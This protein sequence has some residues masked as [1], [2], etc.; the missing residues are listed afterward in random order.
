LAT[1]LVS[2]SS[3]HRT[4]ELRAKAAPAT[5]IAARPGATPLPATS[6]PSVAPNPELEPAAS[7]AQDDSEDPSTDAPLPKPGL[8]GEADPL[9]QQA[10]REA[11]VK[12]VAEGADGL[13][14]LSE[15]YPRD[16]AVLKALVQSFASRSETLLEAMETTRRLLLIAPEKQ[17][18]ADLRY[19]ISR[20]ASAKGKASEL[21]FVVMSQHMGKAGA[22]LLYDM[23]LR[24]PELETRAKIAL[25]SL[26]GS[27]LF[28]PALAI[29]Y[30]LRFAPSCASRLGLLPRARE[31]GDE[32]SAQVLASLI[33]RPAGCRKTR[34]NPC[35]SRCGNEFYEFSETI[36]QIRARPPAKD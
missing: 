17:A 29:A 21:A 30:D 15:Q 23:M 8:P 34:R 26:R 20:A 3:L 7:A 13:R 31:L 27:S 18:D 12:A 9:Q 14:V 10:P 32:R 22:D 6:V 28:S 16:P 1:L 2:V 36:R 35:R 11:L 25:E 24:R 4:L 5:N 19:I 33:R